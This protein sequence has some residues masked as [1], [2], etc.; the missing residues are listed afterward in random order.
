MESIRNSVVI[1][2]QG[3]RNLT[4]EIPGKKSNIFR[5]PQA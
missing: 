1:E 4:I 2:D 3:N 5:K